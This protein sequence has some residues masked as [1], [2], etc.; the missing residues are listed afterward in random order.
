MKILLTAIVCAFII[1]AGTGSVQALTIY[2]A[3]DGINVNLY[4]RLYVF[5]EHDGDGRIT[6]NDSRFGLR[7]STPVTDTLSVFARA[8]F[9]FDASQRARQDVWNDR[10]NTYVG[11]DSPFGTVTLGNFDSV[12]YQVVSYIF[13]L[14]ENEGFVALGNGSTASR[15]NSAAYSS[16]SF[17]GFQLHGQ[18]RHYEADNTPSGDEELVFQ[19]AGSYA[20]KNLTL[21]LGAIIE[22]EDAG[23]GETLFGFSAAYK[24]MDNLSLRLMAEHLKDAGENDYHA[25]LGLIYKYG[26]GDI[27][28]SVGQDPDEETYFSLGT[29][30]KFSK[31]MRLF[32]EYSNGDAINPDDPVISIGMRYDF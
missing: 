5:Y 14:Y 30:Y 4:T 31:P 19:V 1:M 24:L 18:I 7:T 26:F 13:D 22:N 16:P 27:Y 8:E 20:I 10:R 9:R 6:G 15:A 32:A 12:Y 11:L 17:E 29:N 25:A 2:D 23:F 21:A 28:A 3:K